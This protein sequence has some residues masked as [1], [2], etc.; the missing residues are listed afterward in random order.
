MAAKK[1]KILIEV[2]GPPGEPGTLPVEGS[3]ADECIRRLARIIGRRMA[4]DQFERWQREEA[5]RAASHEKEK[6]L[7]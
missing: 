2:C 5:R 6:S 7:S 1:E 3:Q 4:R